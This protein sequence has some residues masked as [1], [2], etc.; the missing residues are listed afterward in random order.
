VKN[1]YEIKAQVQPDQPTEVFIYDEIG[2]WGITAAQ[3]VRD[4]K[5][6][7]DRPINVRINSPGGSVFDGLAIYH[8]LAARP[9]V[10]VTVDG[11]AASIASIIAMAGSKRVMPESA[12]LMIH[13]PW[14]GCIGDATDL[15]EQADLLDKL[16]QTLAGIYAKCSKKT[17][18]TIQSMMDAETWID[19]ATALADG[20]VTELT[21]AQPI[22]A[23]VRAD[24]FA[25][26]P[27]GLVQ[28]AAPAELVLED[29][30][31]W[32]DGTSMAYG[33]IVEIVRSGVLEVPDAG[34]R[35]EASAADPA[36]LIQR[37]QAIPGTDAFLEGEMLVGLN[38]SQL[39]KVE[40]L[41]VIETEDKATDGIR[42]VS[43]TAPQAA[44]R[45]FDKGVRQV[46]DGLGGDGLEAATVKEARSLKAG[47][48]PTENKIR[49]AYRWWARNE[50]FLDAEADS[51]AD[52][53][54]NLWGGAAGRDWFRALHAQL[55]AE[56]ASTETPDNSQPKSQPMNKLLQSLA[57]AGLISS[58]DLAEDAAVAEFEAAFAKVKQA[59]DD[60][61]A[62]LDEIA[63][64]KVVSTVEAAIADGRIAANVKDAWVA[65]IQ[66]DA[67]AA[68]LLAAIQAPKPG[69]DPVGAPA[70][71][72]GKTSDELRAEFDRITDPKQRTAFWSAN[73]AQLLKR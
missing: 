66:A 42:A 64:S 52:V 22:K 47:E 9:N 48:A 57:S 6:L 41:K 11:I 1:W 5:A 65:Q 61:Q 39:S 35:V 27:A 17:K 70:S 45:A 28:A 16:S 49:K 29:Q 34:I 14:T 33:E 59:K 15:R 25:R 4:M 40:D 69:A 60:A 26:T 3:F 2:G 50:R 55:D 62:A 44:R 53:A 71:A 73:K 8:Y 13:N 68:E 10:T 12:Y 72:S 31:G 36:A 7:G 38:F 58:A 63:K 21:H 32:M 18:A 46:E 19:G 51:P 23:S 56:N 43:K 20:F 54:A 24:R 30:V 37:Y 67:K